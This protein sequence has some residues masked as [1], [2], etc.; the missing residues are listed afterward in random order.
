MH[1]AVLF[2][3][4]SLEGGKPGFMYAGNLGMSVVFFESSSSARLDLYDSLVMA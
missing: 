3:E 4:L 1:F 2:L